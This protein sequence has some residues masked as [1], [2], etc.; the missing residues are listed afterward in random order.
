MKRRILLAFAI[1][2]WVLM[3]CLLVMIVL[4]E[5]IVW[6]LPVIITIG[7]ML[8]FGF[9]SAAVLLYEYLQQGPEDDISNLN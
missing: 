6:K 9:L 5:K 4:S 7:G 3:V 2:M 1:F 8:C